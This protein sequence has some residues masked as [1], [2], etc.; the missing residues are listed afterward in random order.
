MLSEDRTQ[1]TVGVPSAGALVL[2]LGSDA[3]GETLIEEHV[4]ALRRVG[5]HDVTVVRRAGAPALPDSL[6]SVR[7]VLMPAAWDSAHEALVVGLFAA[8]RAPL[9]VLPLELELIDDDTLEQL[10]SAGRQARSAHAVVPVGSD[11]RG[12]PFVLTARGIEAIVRDAV[13]RRGVHSL[14]A[15]LAQWSASLVE[16][17]AAGDA[18]GYRLQPPPA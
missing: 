15:L 9:L 14:E 17:P 10:V 6:G 7:V 13:D 3:C 16:L 11:E 2:A 8:G 5:L 18:L 12:R 4:E 1:R